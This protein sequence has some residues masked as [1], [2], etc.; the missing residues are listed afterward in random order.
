MAFQ[1]KSLQCSDCGTTFT[2]TAGEQEF[3]DSKGYTNEPKR[4]PECRQSRKS[5]RYGGRGGSSSG[6]GYNRAPRQMF[7]AVCAECGKET[8]VPFEPREG[9]PVYCSDCYSKT[10]Q[11]R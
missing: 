7:P 9:R 3:F 2:F 4:C 11:S 5:E 8:E 1:D 10:R 6:S